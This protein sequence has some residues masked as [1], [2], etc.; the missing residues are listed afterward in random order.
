[1]AGAKGGWFNEMGKAFDDTWKKAREVNQYFTSS[2]DISVQMVAG[3][4]SPDRGI[5]GHG[6]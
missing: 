6:Q 3:S 2:C 4:P 1:M 5:G